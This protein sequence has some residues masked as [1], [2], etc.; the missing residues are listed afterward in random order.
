MITQSRRNDSCSTDQTVVTVAYKHA[1][2][3]R[4]LNLSVVS[5]VTSNVGINK[6]VCNERTSVI[7]ESVL[8]ILSYIEINR[9]SA[10]TRK[11]SV[12]S[13]CLL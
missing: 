11:K 1:G 6:L 7:S 3:G 8:T 9:N 4:N 12:L 2:S 13:E 5:S 10:E